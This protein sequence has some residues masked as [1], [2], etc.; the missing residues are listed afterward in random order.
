MHLPMLNSRSFCVNLRYHRGRFIPSNNLSGYNRLLANSWDTT[1]TVRGPALRRKS[2]LPP[3]K[4]EV[5][6]IH[7]LVV[8]CERK[9]AT[10]WT[11]TEML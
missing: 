4:P 8:L 1:L 7:L 2:R 3:L 5:A 9:P 6:P 10:T 11:R